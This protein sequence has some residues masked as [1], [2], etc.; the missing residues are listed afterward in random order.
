MDFE[1]LLYAAQ[2][3][4]H[5]VKKEQTPKCYQTKFAP[6]KKEEKKSL[7]VNIQKFLAR[8]EE[9]EKVRL[10]EATKKRDDLLVLRAQD[11]KA[12]KRV[13]AMLKRTKAANKS[14]IADA[15]DDNNTAVT[16]E[17]ETH[18]V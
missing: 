13:Q 8:K 5:K 4:E 9:E 15:V 11:G 14:V 16:L 3:N 6:P 2:K 7:S 18:T 10:E 12:Y 1:S 17:G